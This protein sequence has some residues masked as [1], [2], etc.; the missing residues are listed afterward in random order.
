MDRYGEAVSIMSHEKCRKETVPLEAG[1]PV[2]S[3]FQ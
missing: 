2:V 1:R 3:V